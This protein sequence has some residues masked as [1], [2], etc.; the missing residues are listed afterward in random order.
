LA[1]HQTRGAA[2]TVGAVHLHPLPRELER[3]EVGT[4]QRIKA[5]HRFHPAQNKRSTLQ[6]A[7]LYLFEPEILDLIPT[8]SYFDL[9]E[10]L[11]PPL[12]ERRTPAAIWTIPGYCRR[13]SSAA[14]YLLANRD[15]LLGQGGGEG[16]FAHFVETCGRPRPE[17]SPT[18][19]LLSPP[20]IGPAV[21]I[22]DRAIRVG[23]TAIGDQCEVG[24]DAVLNGCVVMPRAIIGRGARLDQC[25]V[26]EGVR[27]ED[28]TILRDTVVLD[29]PT[30][31]MDM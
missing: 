6:P 30:K 22:R 15:L 8:G 20:V 7:G 26:G 18:A 28:G 11:F 19:T 29:Q 25:V 14:D 10:Q 12:A 17:C 23:P 2:A 13:I 16:E 24:A 3:I 1:F 21:R 9:Q 31:V 27:V 4:N 5:I